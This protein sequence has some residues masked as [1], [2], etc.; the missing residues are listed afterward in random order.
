MASDDIRFMTQAIELA[1]R[2]RYST[3]PNPRVGCVVVK[4]GQVIGEGYHQKTGEPHAEVHALLAAGDGVSG[5]TVYVSLEPCSHSGRTPPCADELIK[6]GVARV[7]YAIDDPNPRVS[8]RGGRRLRE[9]GLAVTTDVL[10]PRARELN[11]GFFTR[12]TLGRPFV[13]LKIAMSLDAKIGLRNGESK[14]IT[15]SL[16]RL[17]VQKLRALSSA[18]ITGSGTVAA[19]N[20]NL[21]VRDESLET[22]GRQPLRVIL[23]TNLGLNSDFNIFAKPS[24]ALVF[25][26]SKD[27]EKSQKFVSRGIEVITVSEQNQR[28]DI[29]KT[30][31]VLAERDCNEVL[32]EAGPRLQR[33]F[34]E[35]GLWDELV[36]YIAPKIIGRSGKDGFDMREINQLQEANEVTLVD[37]TQ[38]GQDLRLTFQPKNI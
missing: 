14:W 37:T 19:D 6:R 7:V 1:E 33:S 22:R 34:I 15:G 10:A 9:A 11:R 20:P 26:C 5:S 32:V 29:G 4:D 18:I 25:S 31:Q 17:D 24:E 13:T 2:G 8:G 3:H 28:V 23:D 36:V 21:T 16:A 35:N 12:N 38:I 27:A 30:L